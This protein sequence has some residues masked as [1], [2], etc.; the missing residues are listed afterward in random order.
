MTTTNHG[1]P[2]VV[3][4]VIGDRGRLVVR[5]AA[6]ELRLAARAGHEVTV[7]TPEGRS[8]P[9]RV[10]VETSDDGLTIREKEGGLL[11]FGGG[12]RVVQLE[13]AV[14]PMAEVTIETASGWL[15]AQGLTGE[16][17]YRAVSG[18]IRLR[19]V[20][21]TI[22]L[23]TVSGEVAIDLAG[24]TDLSLRTVSGDAVVRGGRLDALRV[25]STSGDIRVDSPLA[26][27]SGNKIETL[28]GDVQLVASAGMRVEARTVS[29][30]LMSDLPHRS[31]G[32]MG[33]RTLIVG[34]GSIELAFRSVSGDLRILGGGG[35]IGAVPPEPPQA[36]RPPLPPFTI[37]LPEMPE[38]PELPELPDLHLAGIRLPRFGRSRRDPD[39][40][41]VDEAR[42]GAAPTGAPDTAV[43]ADAAA[44]PTET[45]RMAILRA[46]EQGELDV[47]TAMDRLAELDA[48]AA[49][50]QER[51]AADD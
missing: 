44:D 9:D 19:D 48:I 7:S 45:E 42:T 33:R 50:E 27:P 29:G 38:M 6:A 1:G 24:A 18:D 35:P 3:E 15:D 8:L 2:V 37:D 25:G 13:I 46:L 36:A 14:P 32:R 51:K 43:P 26:G 30:D 47:P 39:H 31:E 4:H 10:I 22:E 17:R 5:L 11:G 23:S 20:A 34:D 12:R 28:S 16:Q 49:S 41:A 21:G 40:D